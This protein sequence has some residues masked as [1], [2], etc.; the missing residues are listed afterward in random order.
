M[1]AFLLCAISG[2]LL[3]PAFD[4]QDGRRSIAE[5]LLASP[6]AVFLR[7]VHYWAAQ[8]FFVGAI[9]HVADHLRAG[10]EG[11]PAPGVW[12]RLVLS[13][14]AIGLLML[15]GFLLRDDPDARQAARIFQTILREIPWAG[16]ALATFLFGRPPGLISVVY[17]QHAATATLIVAA[18]IIEHVRR[19]WPRPGPTVVLSAFISGVAFVVSPGLHDGLDGRIKGPWYFLGLQEGLHWTAYPLVLVAVAAIALGLIWAVPRVGFTSSRRIKRVLLVAAAAYAGLCLVGLF[20]RGED[21]RWQWNRP[22]GPGDLHVGMIAPRRQPPPS[23]TA[24]LP[25]VLGRPEGCLLCHAGLRG[26]GNAHRPE[27]IGCAACHGG[28]VF[29][30]DAAVAHAG[31]IRVPGNLA[32]AQRTCGTSGCHDSIIPRVRRSIMTTM[33]GVVAVDRRAFGELPGPSSAP[34]TVA[35]LGHG[36]ADSHLRQLCA[37][38]HL[39]APKNTW[40]P[41]SQES[42]GGGCNACHLVY[43]AP[44]AA[45]LAAYTSHPS[46]GRLPTLHPALTVKVGDDHCFG[47]H[48]RSGRIATSY[49]GWHELRDAPAPTGP[50]VAPDPA[51]YRQ[52]DDG[53]W[54]VRERPDVHEERGLACIDCHIPAETM[55]S[56]A[57]VARKRDQL[58]I[59]CEDCH[60]PR[61]ATAGP[62]LDAETQKLMQLRGWTLGAGERLAVTST[63]DLLSN[64]VVPADG[65]AHLRL[66]LTGADLPLRPP[67]A[68]C[69]RIG[70]HAR[71]SCGSCHT[72]WAPRC[73]SCHTRF[74]A[75]AEGYD[76][77]ADRAVKGAWQESSGAFEAVPPT[78]G[79]RYATE[80]AGQP[81]AVV[82]TFVPGMIIDL[83][84]NRDAHGRP[85]LVF[86]RRYTPLS[87][88]TIRRQ[89]R[90]CESC[91]NDPVA[92]GYGEGTLRYQVSGPTGRWTFTPKHRLLAQDGLPADAWT[93]FLQG[94]GDPLSKEGVRPFDL[95]E[96]RR[97]LEAGACL[98]C[99]TGDSRVM[100]AALVD[101]DAALRRRSP[102]CA[103][104]VW[105]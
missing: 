99:H 89:A 72:A 56:G 57:V 47:C 70:G 27:S 90:S 39:G 20:L 65:A 15:T 54:L 24:A 13:L 43:S 34:A 25:V 105:R 41:I 98:T 60:A 69:A 4:S 21:W 78:L 29:S 10:T 18:V 51:Q 96:Q 40:G 94:G 81:R 63:G 50:A 55:G 16:R 6:G 95:Q 61:L 17:V 8:V 101:F 12:L 86:Q 22:D 9:L 32:D 66:K 100:R 23:A 91:H 37:S 44:A 84:R 93:G 97:I 26:L 28:N 19:V 14:P 31:M 62:V 35:Q 46:A 59:R 33:A 87:P 79:I 103:V 88:H 45:Q 42:R 83:D 36:A 64:V 77:L 71:L 85:D 67:A 11:R 80:G 52:L 76:L 68:A 7:N 73:A 30:S 92:L 104:P 58:R 2:I 53:R 74:D 49:E 82:D 38:C 75:A 48:S 102:R 5:W 3:V 1:A